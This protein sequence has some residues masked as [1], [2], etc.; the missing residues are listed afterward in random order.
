MTTYAARTKTDSIHNLTTDE[1][2]H[3]VAF[4]KEH[5]PHLICHARGGNVTVYAAPASEWK[6][7][8]AVISAN[9]NR[10]GG[11][12]FEF[13]G[14][15]AEGQYVPKLGNQRYGDGKLKRKDLGDL[16]TALLPHL[17]TETRC[18]RER[19]ATTE[20]YRRLGDVLTKRGLMADHE[21]ISAQRDD[22]ALL[23]ALMLDGHGGDGAAAGAAI[24]DRYLQIRADVECEAI[25]Q[26]F[27]EMWRQFDWSLN[28]TTEGA[29]A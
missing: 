28:T 20:G 23:C 19:A 27:S 9:T 24:R 26:G 6:N 8:L 18:E 1:Q 4:V 29:T 22:G 11:Y 25:A 16:L 12:R 10:N 15:K 14:Y 13:A 21:R 7:R 17:R 5:K 3:I 2:N